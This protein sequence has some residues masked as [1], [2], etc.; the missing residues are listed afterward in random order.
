MA[1][2]IVRI[3]G[4]TGE[5]SFYGFETSD[6]EALG[7]TGSVTKG[8][9]KSGEI[10]CLVHNK[11]HDSTEVVV[12]V[13]FQGDNFNDPKGNFDSEW[14]ERFNTLASQKADQILFIASMS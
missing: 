12:D 2:T 4:V 11:P 10:F 5:R 14:G 6:G 3:C 8:T 1:K 7:Q 9:L 13:L